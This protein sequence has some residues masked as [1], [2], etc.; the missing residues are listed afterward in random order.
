[1][2]RRRGPTWFESRV[3]IVTVADSASP[4]AD[5]SLRSTGDYCHLEQEVVFLEGVV[6]QEIAVQ[7]IDDQ[8]AEGEE[9]FY[10]QLVEGERLTNA[11]LHGNV[12]SKVII[13]DTEDC[14]L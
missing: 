4:R 1:M 10:V 5:C 2:F 9:A 11:I 8:V 7:L 3:H 12:R 6:T 14:E 13:E